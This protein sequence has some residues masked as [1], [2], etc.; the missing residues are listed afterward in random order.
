MIIPDHGKLCNVADVD[1]QRQMVTI[2]RDRLQAMIKTNTGYLPP[3]ANVI[4]I[5]P[6]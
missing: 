1:M 2:V 6:A 4:E 3:F 5:C